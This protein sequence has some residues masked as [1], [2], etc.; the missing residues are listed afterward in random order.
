MYRI[1]SC[2]LWSW[3][4]Q[5]RGGSASAYSKTYMLNFLLSLEQV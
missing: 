5:T 4:E 3:V 1:M 2:R